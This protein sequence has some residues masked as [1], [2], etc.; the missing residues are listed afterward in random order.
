MDTL[1]RQDETQTPLA[2]WLDG[3]GPLDGPELTRLMRQLAMQLAVRH[4][5]G[6]LHGR[7]TIDAVV[8]AADGK[9]KLLD[10]SNEANTDIQLTAELTPPELRDRGPLSIP[11]DL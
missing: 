5:Q 4:E 11:A 10:G 1:A 9:A 8:V 2:R 6:R 3:H 7:L